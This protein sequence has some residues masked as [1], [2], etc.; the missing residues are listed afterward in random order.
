MM[1]ETEGQANFY[2]NMSIE[3]FVPLDHPLRAI[4]PLIDKQAIR[5]ECRGL[6]SPVGRPSIPP[7]Q[8]FLALVGGYLLGIAS[9]RKLVMELQC[10]MALR[11]FVGL[12]LEEQP[13]DASTF[14]QNRRRRFDRSGVLER[15][16]DQTVQRAIK[17]K[18]ISE[19]VSADGTLVRANASFKS[20]V[21]IEVAMDSEE[22][23]KRLRSSDEKE[24]EKQDPPRGPEDP[25]NPTVD[26]RGEKRGNKTHRSKTDP[27]CRFVSKG[28]SGTGAYPGYTVNALME[29]RNRILLGVGVE[30]FQSSSSEER[31]ALNLLDRAKRRFRFKPTSLGTDKGF[32]HEE[33]IGKVFRRKIEPHI[34]ADKRGSSRL[35]MRVR[36]RQRGRPYYWSQRCRK[37]IEELFGEGKE[38][39]GLRRFRRRQLYRV[40]QETWLIGWVLNLK[41]LAKLLTVQP[42]TA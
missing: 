12:G 13:W 29:N 33:F 27:D 11:W 42:A 21:P 1:G 15:L 39:H 16:F 28:S 18:L 7:E 36:M 17:E 24:E 30:I 26:F 32:F 35:H 41:R 19:H 9:E 10:N 22:Y 4:R 6:Y 23:K 20:F 38:Y 37:K 40:R 2:Y 31:G 14:S 5:R 3:Q 8:L 34:A 25:G